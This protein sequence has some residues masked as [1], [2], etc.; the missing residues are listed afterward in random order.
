MPVI[1]TIKDPSALTMT[2]VSEF[3]AEPDRVWRVWEDPRQ[4]EKWWGPPTWPATFHE[5]N[6]V[7]GGRSKYFMTGP[8]GT[9]MHGWFEFTAISAPKSLSL[10]DGF[11]DDEGNPTGEH[12]ITKMTAALESAAGGTRMSIT[13]RF[14]SIEQLDEML[15]MGMEEGMREALGQIDDVLAG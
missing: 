4:L 7:V 12:G 10:D 8:D 2:I 6:F 5:H 11:A 3:E 13:T 1:N 9:K 14:E 15:A